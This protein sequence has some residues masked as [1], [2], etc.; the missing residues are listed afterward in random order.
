MVRVGCRRSQLGFSKRRGTP[1]PPQHSSS[2]SSG[3]VGVL[4]TQLGRQQGS[5]GT[6]G[7]LMYPYV[8][9][10]LVLVH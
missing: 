10:V 8:F 6:M 3:A 1:R 2:S 4:A 7:C 9:Q 5:S